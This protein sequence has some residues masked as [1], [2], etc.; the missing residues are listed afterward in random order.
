[1][2]T[3]FHHDSGRWKNRIVGGPDLPNAYVD[4]EAAA[5]DGR[6]FAEFLGSEYRLFTRARCRGAG[7]AGRATP[8]WRLHA[9]APPTAWC[10]HSLRGW[11]GSRPG[12]KARPARARTPCGWSWPPRWPASRRR[13]PRVRRAAHELAAEIHRTEANRLELVGETERAA[14][15]RKAA[16]VDDELA[17]PQRALDDRHPNG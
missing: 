14:L 6:G 3:F 11:T 8:A 15:Q 9:P 4:R 2:E 5:R 16:A 10:R 13:C 17:A 1:M 12:R 7:A